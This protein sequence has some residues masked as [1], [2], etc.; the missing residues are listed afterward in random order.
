[1]NKIKGAASTTHYLL[2][3]L[4]AIHSSNLTCVILAFQQ[5]R[6]PVRLLNLFSNLYHLI[7]Y[8]VSTPL[9]QDFYPVRKNVYHPAGKSSLVEYQT[10][11]LF[12]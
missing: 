8:L 3:F 10:V 4:L 1:M 6:C 9:S 11:T 7:L 2:L 5:S 12:T